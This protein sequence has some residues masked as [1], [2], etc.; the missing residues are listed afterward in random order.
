[1]VEGL[2][3][4][5]KVMVGKNVRAF[6]YRLWNHWLGRPDFA[7]GIEDPVCDATYKD[8]ICRT[9]DINTRELVSFIF[10]YIV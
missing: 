10:H 6:R 4:G 1:M 2:M 5:E 3:D 8:I 7:P 9:A